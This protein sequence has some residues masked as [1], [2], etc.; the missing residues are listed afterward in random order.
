MSDL[1]GIEI[2]DVLGLSQPLTKLI[3]VVAKGTGLLYQPIHKKRMAKASAEEIKTITEACQNNITAPI[4]YQKDGVSITTDKSL[5]E[6][7]QRTACRSLFQEVTKQQNIEDIVTYAK[8]VLETEQSVS[9]EPVSKTWLSNFFESAG[10]I[11]D[12]DLQKLWGKI[13]AGEI[14]CPNSY[15]MRTLNLLRNMSSAEAHLF[16]KISAYVICYKNTYFIPNPEEF[17]KKFQINYGQISSLEECGLVSAPT[18]LTVQ[19]RIKP[20]T[21]SCIFNKNLVAILNSDFDGEAK[22]DDEIYALTKAG[23]ELYQLVTQQPNN[24]FFLEYAKT[25]KDK[26]NHIAVKV[27]KIKEVIKVNEIE[28]IIFDKNQCIF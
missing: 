23:S 11:E 10:H 26:K 3:D 25:F 6:L 16:N 1:K 20:N 22:R 19:Y 27:Y 24:D 12:E 4:T 13:L 2:T 15:S 5:L 21:P 17:S 7:L 14:K 18:F 28:N 9:E 8:E